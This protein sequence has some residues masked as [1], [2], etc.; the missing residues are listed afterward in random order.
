MIKELIYLQSKDTNIYPNWFKL[1]LLEIQD[2]DK[3]R[4]TKD[5]F[6]IP[7]YSKQYTIKKFH[8][9]LNITPSQYLNK[10][11]VDKAIELLLSTELS[12]L[13]IAFE[14]GFNN[15]EYFDKIFKKIIG[16]TPLRYKQ[17]QSKFLK[18]IDN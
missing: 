4:E 12:I 1:L 16:L 8:K 18:E 13:D 9:Y 6:K 5:I 17:T 14:C 15:V 2:L 7:P 10:K 11:K 3:I